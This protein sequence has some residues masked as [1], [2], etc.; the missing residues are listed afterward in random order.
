MANPETL[1][2][3]KLTNEWLDLYAASGIAVGTQVL[4]NTRGKHSCFLA[5]SAAEP[6]IADG[7]EVYPTRQAIVDEGSPGLWGRAAHNSP[8][9]VVVIQVDKNP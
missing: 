9:T 5:E 6:V 7:V 1:E 8:F 3:I 2:S 4:I